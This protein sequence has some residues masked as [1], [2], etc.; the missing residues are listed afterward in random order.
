[1]KKKISKLLSSVIVFYTLLYNKVYSGSIEP[2]YG[3]IE[4]KEETIVELVKKYISFMLILPIIISIGAI[5]FC[6][7]N[8]M[9]KKKKYFFIVFFIIIIIFCIC[10]LSSL[11]YD[12]FL[13]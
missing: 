5:V 10:K 2:A 9:S 8:K 1:M 12:N 7:K 11:I 3:V 4:P 13:Y 6:I